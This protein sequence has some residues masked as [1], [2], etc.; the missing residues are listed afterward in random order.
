MATVANSSNRNST[1]FESEEIGVVPNKEAD[2]ILRLEKVDSRDEGNQTNFT[3]LK[4]EFEPGDFIF[5][6][7]NSARRQHEENT[8]MVG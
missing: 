8:N 2:A 5:S 3:T 7:M 6:H 4:L 1:L